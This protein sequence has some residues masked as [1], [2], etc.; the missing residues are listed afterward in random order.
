M[1]TNAE[2]GRSYGS[3]HI[4]PAQH[5]E[6]LSSN[7]SITGKENNNKKNYLPRV[8]LKIN[9]IGEHKIQNKALKS[10]LP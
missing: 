5:H 3:T 7:P 8:I 9:V 6:A 4:V 2:K 1:I 10:F